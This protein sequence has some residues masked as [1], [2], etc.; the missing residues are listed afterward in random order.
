MMM[1]FFKFQNSPPFLMIFELQY[2]KYCRVHVLHR[3]TVRANDSIEMRTASGRA[4]TYSNNNR[5]RHNLVVI[6]N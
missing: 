1:I 2:L 4:Q 6:R 3:V 5:V